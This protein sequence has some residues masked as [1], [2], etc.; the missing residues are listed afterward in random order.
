MRT[1]LAHFRRLYGASP[2][3]LLAFIASF[4]LAGY[5]STELFKRMTIRVAIW[6]IGAAVGHDVILMPLY[7]LANHSFSGIWHRK[8]RHDSVMWINYLRFPTVISLILLL[9]YYPEISR[10]RTQQ[11]SDSGLGN[12]PYFA[13]WLLATGILFG[14]SAFTYAIRLGRAVRRPA[15]A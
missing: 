11:L 1:L 13:H 9:I 3:H 15:T 2:L 8:T 12:H 5:A 10:R 6:F 4:A 7:A 14:I